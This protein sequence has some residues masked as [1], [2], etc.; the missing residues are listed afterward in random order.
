[1]PIQEHFY[2]LSRI[3]T[4][5]GMSPSP[6]LSVSRYIVYLSYVPFSAALHPSIW[7][8]PSCFRAPQTNIS[9]SST[10]SRR[11]AG[12]RRRNLTHK[13]QCHCLWR[14][15]FWTRIPVKKI[16]RS[17]SVRIVELISAL[18]ILHR[19]EQHRARN[20]IDPAN[21]VHTVI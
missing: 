4:A 8:S 2:A 14:L 12:P 10:S 17:R 19:I 21:S 5:E 16:P 9:G 1:M 11:L 7:I 13:R 20:R 15:F 6:I 18:L 3:I